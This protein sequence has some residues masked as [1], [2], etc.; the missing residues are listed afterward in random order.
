MAMHV[1][2]VTWCDF[3]VWSTR[4]TVIQRIHKNDEFLGGVIFKLKTFFQH[5]LS[6]LA[7]ES[8]LSSKGKK[9]VC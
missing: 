7:A 3:C 4:F 5:L 1:V 8:L 6:A 2:Q 9:A